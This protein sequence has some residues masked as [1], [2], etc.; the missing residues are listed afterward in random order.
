MPAPCSH[1]ELTDDYRCAPSLALGG[2]RLAHP[3]GFQLA[4]LVAYDIDALVGALELLAV[5]PSCADA[6]SGSSGFYRSAHPTEFSVIPGCQ[7]GADLL[8]LL[9][10]I[11]HQGEA[12]VW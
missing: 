6:R 8:R 5:V 4:R 9:R 12:I 3:G 10:S 2:S 11:C 1:R 7:R